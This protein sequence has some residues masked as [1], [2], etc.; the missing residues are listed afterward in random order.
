[1]IVDVVEDIVYV[2]VKMEEKHSIK[3]KKKGRRERK[4]KKKKRERRR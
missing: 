1:M 2:D 4:K 3:E